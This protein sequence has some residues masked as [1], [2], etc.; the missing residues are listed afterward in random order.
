M[1]DA[2]KIVVRYLADVNAQNR[3]DA[4][5]LICPEL[6]DTW[7]KA[8]DG[9]NG[10]F[11]VTVTHATFQSASSSSSGVDLKYSLEVKGIKTGSTAVNPVTFTIVAKAGGPKICGEK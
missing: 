5:T 2:R 3:T 9:P 11:T 6:V 10:D 1:T 4:A 8:I 7:R